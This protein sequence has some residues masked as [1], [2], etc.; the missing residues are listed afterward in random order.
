MNYEY[1]WPVLEALMVDLRQKGMIIPQDIA[2]DLKSART[3]LTIYKAQPATANVESELALYL[4]KIEPILLSL[5]ESEIGE[6]YADVWQ[7]KIGDAR[8]QTGEK[9]ALTSRFIPGIPKGEHWLRIKTSDM[10][11]DGEINILLGKLN[12]T[13]KPQNDGYL[14]IYGNQE[15]VITFIKEVRKKIGKGKLE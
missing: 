2:D 12:L 8:T 13:S 9:S 1:I 5:A 10:I 11:S 7:K 4:E 6:E 14:L 3:L 15:N